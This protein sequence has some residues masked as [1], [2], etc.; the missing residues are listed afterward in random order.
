[1]MRHFIE[2]SGLGLVISAMRDAVP[3]PKSRTAVSREIVVTK[4]AASS[5]SSSDCQCPVNSAGE[6]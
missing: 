2:P 4:W 6:E 1:M 5:R 3:V